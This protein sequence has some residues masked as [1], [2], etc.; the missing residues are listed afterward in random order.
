[1]TDFRHRIGQNPEGP[2][3]GA[4]IRKS[5]RVHSEVWQLQLKDIYSNHEIHERH[6]NFPIQT[7]VY[8]VSFV[9]KS[10]SHITGCRRYRFLDVTRKLLKSGDSSYEFRSALTAQAVVVQL[11]PFLGLLADFKSRLD[12]LDRSRAHIL[13]SST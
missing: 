13:C 8:S 6:E 4:R 3:F 9:V 1:M 2:E 12:L 5:F 10:T 11:Q 7:F